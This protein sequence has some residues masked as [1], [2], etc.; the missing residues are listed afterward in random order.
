MDPKSCVFLADVTKQR[1]QPRYCRN[2]LDL[3]K[4]KM[5]NFL[6]KSSFSKW[7]NNLIFQ[8]FVDDDDDGTDEEEDDV[9][10]ATS[11]LSRAKRMFD[12]LGFTFERNMNERHPDTPPVR[13]AGCFYMLILYF[14][15][16]FQP[17]HEHD[18]K[19]WPDSDTLFL[20][21]NKKQHIELIFERAPCGLCVQNHNLNESFTCS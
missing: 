19:T 3:Y 18:R 7:T 20:L 1:N 10:I 21:P 16:C 11:G 15:L 12:N 5:L 2:S 6:L 13:S 4:A 8:N 17:K 14:F 9:D